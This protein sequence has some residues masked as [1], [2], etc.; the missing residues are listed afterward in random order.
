ML[1]VPV[2]NSFRY[3]ERFTILEYIKLV[4]K[5]KVDQPLKQQYGLKQVKVR[6][7]KGTK[8]SYVF[9]FINNPV[10]LLNH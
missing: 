8:S 10:L 9:I 1:D 6:K 7:N 5:A 2:T 4:K 3:N